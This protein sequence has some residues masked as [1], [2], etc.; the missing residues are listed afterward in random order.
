VFASAATPVQA[1][2]VANFAQPGGNL[3]GISFL[4][5]EL[6]GKRIELLKAA[7]PDARRIAIVAS[8][9]HPATRPS[10]TRRKSQRRAMGL[11]VE[12]FEAGGS[13]QLDRA[14][15]AIQKSRCDAVV[16]FPIQSI[17][18]QTVPDCGVVDPESDPG[19]FRLGAVRRG[20]QPDVVRGGHARVFPADRH[21]CRP[22]S[23]GAKPAELPVELPL[24]IELVINLEAARRLGLAVPRSVIL[25]AD[26]VIE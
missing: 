22:H 26:K 21:V 18:Q 3:T 24:H 2:L 25:R 5:L 6:V 14:L 9:Q 16:M 4:A 7:M 20:R 17:H 19:R 15:E 8:A 10:G 23:Q 1:G 11:E 13:A 12:Y